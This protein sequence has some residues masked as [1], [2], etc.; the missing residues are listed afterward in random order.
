MPG[1]SDPD[2]SGRDRGS[3]AINQTERHSM[4]TR[5]IV[6]AIPA[7]VL[8]GALTACDPGGMGAAGTR[9]PS[10]SATA[11]TTPGSGS[12][13]ASGSASRPAQPG[14]GAPATPAKPARAGTI[15][16]ALS[17]QPDDP[18]LALLNLVNTTGHPVTW[19]GSPRVAFR[20]AHDDTLAVPVVNLDVPGPADSITVAPGG[21]VFGALRL[22]RGDKQD[23]HTFVAT[24]IEIG[25]PG[26]GALV[27][28]E[29]SLANGKTDAQTYAEYDITSVKV[30]TLQPIANGVSAGL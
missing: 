25:L 26:G 7:M 12:T 28:P 6:L 4:R 15:T 19:K 5:T 10:A 16:A 29:V 9:A 8:L 22:V 17:F 1:T 14:S 18:D 24:T 11:A 30:G 20:N 21:G 27:V 2:V 23:E 3:A 13:A